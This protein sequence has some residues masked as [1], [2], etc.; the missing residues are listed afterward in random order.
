MFGFARK[1]EVDLLK[2][3]VS[4]LNKEV[5]ALKKEASI[6]RSHLSDALVDIHLLMT[7]TLKNKEFEFHCQDIVIDDEIQELTQ[8][9]I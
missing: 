7:F 9:D 5:D 6:L 4:E 8:G 1:K 3:Q 2:V